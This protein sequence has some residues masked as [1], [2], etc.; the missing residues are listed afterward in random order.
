MLWHFLF[1]AYVSNNIVPWGDIHALMANRLIA[2]DKCPGVRPIG[3]GESLRRILGKPICFATRLDLEVSCGVDQLSAGVK[4]GIEGAIHAVNDLYMAHHSLPAG[5]GLLLVDA[6]NA[7]NSLNRAAMLWNVR[8]LWPRCSRFVFNTYQCWGTL[9]VR[10]SDEFLFSKEGVTQGDPLSMFLYAV[11]T[12]PLIQSLKDP[13]L[14][15]QLWYADDAAACGDI[16]N[17]RKWFDKLLEL[18]PKFGYYPNPEKCYLV[19]D[20]SYVNVAKLHFDDLG[21]QIV[22]HHRYLGGFIGDVSAKNAFVKAKVDK[23]SEDVCCLSR[24]AVSQPQAAYTAVTKFLQ[25]EWNFVL[26]TIPDSG[27]M[28]CSLESTIYSVFLPAVFGTEISLQERQLF[29]LPVKYG[30]LGIPSACVSAPILYTASR[31][32][33][34]CIVDTIISH[35]SFEIAAHETT[36]F[37]A[38]SDYLKSCEQRYDQLYDNVLQQF[39]SF[40]QRSIQRARDNTMS[41]WLSVVPVEQNH[42]DLTAQEFCDALAVRYR[43]PLLGLPSRL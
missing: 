24:I 34:K 33:T 21:V 6:K 35:S 38:R 28:F 2:L 16:C 10:G 39:D 31:N 18:G 14:C 36:V 17:V 43:K 7:F 26:R 40:H 8:V 30:G 3:V 27:D 9:L 15:T 32:S 41:V 19:V 12:L 11:G 42:F 37:S 29:S 1:V 20:N 25:H 5:W 13:T 4:S 23:W 22:N